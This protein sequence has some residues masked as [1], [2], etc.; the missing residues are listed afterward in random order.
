MNDR[1]ELDRL[2]KNGRKK[3]ETVYASDKVWEI[4]FNTLKWLDNV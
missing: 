3:Y 1:R 2:W 4:F